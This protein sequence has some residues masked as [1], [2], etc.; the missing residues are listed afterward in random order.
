MIEV[1][2]FYVSDFWVWLGLTIG[3]Y[4]AGAALMMAGVGL[5]GVITRFRGGR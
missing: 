4:T 3:V 1:L 5:S 2:Q